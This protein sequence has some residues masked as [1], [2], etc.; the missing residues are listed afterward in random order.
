MVVGR[1]RCSHGRTLFGAGVSMP[2]TVSTHRRVHATAGRA[3]AES[4]GARRPRIRLPRRPFILRAPRPAV[5][6]QLQSGE[7]V[8]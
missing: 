1:T 7:P 6:S 5:G 3:G 8:D 2:L 4:A